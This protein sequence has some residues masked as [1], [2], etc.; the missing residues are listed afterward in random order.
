[1]SDGSKK[2]TGKRDVPEKPTLNVTL[3]TPEPAKKRSR[4]SSGAK[5]TDGAAT[6]D[7]DL[8]D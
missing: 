1:M 7:M 5:K 8:L 2:F 4:R 3:D 6:Y